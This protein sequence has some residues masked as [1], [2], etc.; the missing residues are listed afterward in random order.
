MDF[1]KN[2]EIQSDFDLERYYKILC[3]EYPDFLNPYVAL[4]I[5]Q[6]LGGIG[7]L[8]GTDWTPLFH[9]KFFYSRLNHSVGVA[10]IIWNFTKDKKQTL[11]GLFHDIS[12]PVFKHCIDFM[13]GDHE[14]QE[15]TEDLTDRKSVV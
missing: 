1:L 12:T 7:L 11:A 2:P 5:M 4:P 15:S 9:N 14:K 3:P 10:L 6:R 13:N 8:C